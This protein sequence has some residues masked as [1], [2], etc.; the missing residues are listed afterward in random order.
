M[1]LKSRILFSITVTAVIAAAAK[2]PAVVSAA[3]P[4]SFVVPAQVL[5]GYARALTVR[6]I[7]LT[8]G[9]GSNSE[10]VWATV[11]TGSALANIECNT[12]STGSPVSG[13]YTFN[14]S[15]QA[16]NQANCPALM[17]NGG[18][19][20]DN[21]CWFSSAL[22]GGPEYYVYSGPLV[23]DTVSFPGSAPPLALQH[24]AFACSQSYSTCLSTAANCPASLQ[25]CPPPQTPIK[26]PSVDG[27]MFG[28]T[29]TPVSLVQQLVDAGSIDKVVA[30]CYQPDPATLQ[31]GMGMSPVNSYVAFGRGA[32][33]MGSIGIPAQIPI[34]LTSFNSSVT[35]GAAGSSSSIGSVHFVTP[36]Q[37]MVVPVYGA[38]AA[39]NSGTVINVAAG[40]TVLWDSGAAGKFEIPTNGYDAY[41]AY[42]NAALAVM[43][44]T[45]AGGAFRGKF[46]E[47]QA[48]GLCGANYM[49][50]GSAVYPNQGPATCI[51]IGL[52]NIQNAT[53][54][55]AAFAALQSLYPP[56]ITLGLPGYN[57]SLATATPI[58]ACNRSQAAVCSYV[59]PGSSGWIAA[60][61]FTGRWVQFD[62]TAPMPGYPW[63][64]GTM[65]VLETS[66]CEWVT[67]GGS[68]ATT[69]TP[70]TATSS[71]VSS[72]TTISPSSKPNSAQSIGFSRCLF[73]VAFFGPLVIG[74]G[75]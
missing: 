48:E 49:Q 3:V 64:N 73:I 7:Q 5:P 19:F 15:S 36:L 29:F 2:V 53:E 12:G 31:C 68:S 13:V 25:T 30:L 74:F 26:P 39:G 8:Y 46:V 41:L 33:P 37:N 47:C 1:F 18:C 9:T 45:A 75:V 11:D 22:T 56:Q 60:P 44:G 35:T 17:P 16:V 57:L 23:N 28:F 54:A 34:S 6:Q 14:S 27:V 58:L 72:S 52:A 65:S 4:G 63:S 67:T 61:L 21:T 55:A 59:S 70:T 66:T 24:A 38:T 71:P 20:S 40:V 51:A 43:N 62:A 69:T 50:S 10:T 42:F 32:Q